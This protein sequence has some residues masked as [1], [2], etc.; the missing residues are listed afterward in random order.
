MNYPIITIPGGV[1][2][3]K[4]SP[5]LHCLSTG[6]K[7]NSKLKRDCGGTMRPMISDD[8]DKATQ[9]IIIKRMRRGW[10]EPTIITPVNIAFRFHVA[11]HPEAPSLAGRDLSNSYQLYED[12]LQADQWKV[13][14]KGIDKGFK[15]KASEG[16]GIIENDSLIQG[17][18]GSGFVY[19]C[20]SCQWGFKGE[21]RQ[22]TR[23]KVKMG[24]PGVKSCPER[25]L[26]I[27]ITDMVM[28]NGIFINNPTIIGDAPQ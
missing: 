11:K 1:I 26:T 28:E 22:F 9:K 25:K 7:R 3:K 13:K 2:S 4:N 17:H 24:C 19:L 8:I 5:N 6:Q 21:R 18:N 23:K 20:F 12:L 10:G 16:A 15:Y 14:N 27:E